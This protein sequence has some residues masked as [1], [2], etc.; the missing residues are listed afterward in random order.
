MDRSQAS[1]FVIRVLVENGRVVVECFEELE[2]HDA[3][4]AATQGS[5]PVDPVVLRELS[6]YGCRAKGSCWIERAA[7]PGYEEEMQCEQGQTD[8]DGCQIGCTV[9]DIIRQSCQMR[10]KLVDIPSRLR[11]SKH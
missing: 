1:D 2:V 10:G 11:A 8:A 7:C 4:Y 9:L 3:E 6:S 5:D